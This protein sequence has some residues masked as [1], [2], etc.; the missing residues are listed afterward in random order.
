MILD[1]LVLHNFGVYRGRQSIT[2]TPPEPKRP[3]VLFGGLNGGGKT[4]LLDGLQLAL[5]GKGAHCSNRGSLAYPDYLER[6]INTRVPKT[7]GASVEIFFRHRAEGEEHEFQI[8]RSWSPSSSGT[9]REHLEIYR[10]GLESPL[11]ADA[12]AER[13]EEFMPSGISHLFLFDGEKIEELA[14]PENSAKLLSSAIGSL[15]G[16]DLVDQLSTDLLVLE[17]RKR[18]A[19]SGQQDRQQVE[20]EKREVRILEERVRD[21]VDVRAALQNKLGEA[22]KALKKTE[23]K[24]RREGGELYDE[25]TRIEAEQTAHRERV[26]ETIQELMDL[27]SGAAPLALV[28]SSLAAIAA[29]D[30]AEAEAGRAKALGA[31]LSKRDAKLTR[32]IAKLGASSKLRSFVDDFLEKDRDRRLSRSSVE[33]YLQLSSDARVSLRTVLESLPLVDKQASDLLVRLERRQVD[34]DRLDR[35]LASV[36]TPDAI[37]AL[38]EQR[39]EARLALETARVRIQAIDGELSKARRSHEHRQKK[40]VRLIE[41][42][43]K[44]EF[45]SEDSLRV[46]KHAR[47]ARGTLEVFRGSLVNRHVERI[48]GLILESFRQL[49]RKEALVTSLSID[50]QTFQ[51]ELRD[52]HSEILEP[53]RLS[54]GERQLLAV[55]MLWGLARA[56][57]RPLPAVI[58]TPLGRLDSTH[59]SHLVKR[60]FP[61][62][63]HQVLLLST[64]EEIDK[65]YFDQLKSHVGR[66]YVLDFDDKSGSTEVREGYFW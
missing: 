35:Q 6:C 46:V 9:M 48:Q 50:P 33:R 8:V 64:D 16:L 51:V 26:D 30:E 41:T 13:V 47:K 61:Y 44:S 14:N 12:W 49:L 15:L 28:A 17:R 4:T 59:R 27:A 21:L 23:K 7:D 54:A 25:R 58:D 2:L 31:V 18:T 32:Q 55:S 5:Y 57:G 36:P 34:L 3:V 56:S 37:E 20:L 60:Y 1:E 66:S 63:S 43:I 29:Q 11:L 53:Q 42:Q 40:L 52:R 22:E 62:A 19:A 38:R 39:D 45:A 24:F 10:D 65:R